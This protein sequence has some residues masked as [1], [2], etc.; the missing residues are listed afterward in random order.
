VAGSSTRRTVGATEVVVVVELDVVDELSGEVEDVG[1]E[2]VVEG[3]SELVDVDSTDEDVLVSGCV[4]VV[5]E[6]AV[7]TTVVV[8]GVLAVVSTL[9]VD[10][11]ASVVVVVVNVG[12]GGAGVVV[13]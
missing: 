13:V 3:G 1:K 11:V 5:V 8:V 10:V 4:V 12:G 9:V 7:V 2:E 6:G